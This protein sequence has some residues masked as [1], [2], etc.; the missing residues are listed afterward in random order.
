MI[1]LNGRQ[2]ESKRSRVSKM[3]QYERCTTDRQMLAKL[4]L[5]PE[6]YLRLKTLTKL[7]LKAESSH[8]VY[9]EYEALYAPFCD[10]FQISLGS[11]QKH[12]AIMTS[13]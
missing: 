11:I 12:E 4:L 1:E 2:I 3:K 9:D 6:V 7:A 10:G 13:G 5:C 8:S